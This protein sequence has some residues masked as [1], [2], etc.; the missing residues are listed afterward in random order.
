MK[1]SQSSSNL[2]IEN[3]NTTNPNLVYTNSLHSSNE[4]GTNS[5]ECKVIDAS[6]N[7]NI[8]N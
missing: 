7:T 4:I 8:Q 6:V 3:I 2:I 1:T 5:F